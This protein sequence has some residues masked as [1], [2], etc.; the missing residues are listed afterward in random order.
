MRACTSILRYDADAAPRPDDE[1]KRRDHGE[2]FPVRAIPH[3][4]SPQ[5]I[6]SILASC[7]A[8]P[9]RRHV[10]RRPSRAFRRRSHSVVIVHARTHL[11]SIPEGVTRREAKRTMGAETTSLCLSVLCIYVMTAPPSSPSPSETMSSH[12]TRV[13]KAIIALISSWINLLLDCFKN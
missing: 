5:L 8:C 6:S 7:Y 10:G 4:R 1:R 12:P 3:F 11:E 9:S 13:G 2:R